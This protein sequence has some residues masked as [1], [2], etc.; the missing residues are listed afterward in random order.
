MDT[1]RFINIILSELSLE[2]MKQEEKLE[3]AINENKDI[4]EKIFKVKECLNKLV[5]NELMIH[6][7][8][9][10]VENSNKKETE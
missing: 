4:S 5:T 2:N 8:K 7:F 6:K 10:L 3:K 1:N 9:S